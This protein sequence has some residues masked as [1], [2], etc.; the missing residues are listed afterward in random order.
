MF[1]PLHRNKANCLCSGFFGFRLLATM[2]TGKLAVC[3]GS[4]A[5]GYGTW[6]PWECGGL[7]SPPQRSR[8]LWR[9]ADC[10]R[11]LGICFLPLRSFFTDHSLFF[12]NRITIGR[13]ILVT[14]H[15]GVF[16]NVAGSVLV[17]PAL[18]LIFSSVQTIVSQRVEPEHQAGSA[19]C[20]V[21]CPGKVPGSRVLSGHR[22]CDNRSILLKY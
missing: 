9:F 18:S 22:W 2:C 4:C 12:S 11:Y 13:H 6:Q 17:P 21:M 20:A 1:G 5:C 8:W 10:F 3:V 19:S 15:R 7:M 16:R 14:R